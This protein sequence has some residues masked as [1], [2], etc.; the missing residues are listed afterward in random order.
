[1]IKC[2]G[3][4]RRVNLNMS[5]RAQIFFWNP[6][7]VLYRHR[8]AGPSMYDYS[9]SLWTIKGAAWAA[10]GSLR[11]PRQLAAS[12]G[13][14][15]V[16]R[17][18]VGVHG[19]AFFGE[20]LRR[21]HFACWRPAYVH[22]IDPDS[23]MHPTATATATGAS[24]CHRAW[25]CD[26]HKDNQVVRCCSAH[27]RPC[28]D[29]GVVIG[30]GFG[31]LIGQLQKVGLLIAKRSVWAGLTVPAGLVADTLTTFVGCCLCQA[32][33]LPH[34]AAHAAL[35]HGCRVAV[36]LQLSYH[37][38]RCTTPCTMFHVCSGRLAVSMWTHRGAALQHCGFPHRHDPPVV[39]F[40]PHVRRPGWRLRPW[41]RRNATSWWLRPSR[42]STGCG[43]RDAA[44]CRWV[45]VRVR[46]LL[47][48]VWGCIRAGTSCCWSQHAHAHAHAAM[49]A[50][51]SSFG[52]S[53]AFMDVEM[54]YVLVC[55][56]P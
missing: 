30:R 6:A 19:G 42:R 46:K 14:D 7:H 16:L 2:N 20:R 23:L 31:T 4:I 29:L 9:K 50:E 22:C 13:S 12:C 43:S 48:W 56:P 10:S 45:R 32:L 5:R 8:N 27:N 44:S 1:M 34:C 28:R 54:R 36:W 15:Q 41:S 11:G 3:A 47:V 35:S 26:N 17:C 53:R 40:I 51:A 49:Y 18:L 38:L 55:H 33:P 24:L 37:K 39:R 25:V 52:S 21:L